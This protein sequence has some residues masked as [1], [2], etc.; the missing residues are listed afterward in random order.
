MGTARPV[1]VEVA[2]PPGTPVAEVRDRLLKAVGRHDGRLFTREG[3]SRTTPAS[4]S[5]RSSTGAARAARGRRPD[6]GSVHL[7]A[8]GEHGIGRAVEATVRIDD[9]DVS[10]LHAVLRVAVDGSGGTAVHDL[11]S[12]DGTTVD[13]EPVTPSR[14]PST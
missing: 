6:I 5:R 8:P 10:R 14:P 13:G 2:A 4:V 11:G 12:T 3:R 1:D 7:L 9:P